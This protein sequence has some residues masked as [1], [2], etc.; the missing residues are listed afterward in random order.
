MQRLLP[1]RFW[2]GFCCGAGE[3]KMFKSESLYTGYAFGVYPVF[4]SDQKRTHPPACEEPGGLLR[5]R[6]INAEK[7]AC[8]RKMRS[9]GCEWRK[10]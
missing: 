3:E 10:E 4:L 1:R 7:A 5:Y 2:Q 8:R 6:S 9:G